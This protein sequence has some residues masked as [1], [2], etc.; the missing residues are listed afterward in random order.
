MNSP[1]PAAGLTDLLLFF[2]GR[3]KLF[4]VEGESMLPSL[5][6]RQRLL[7][8]PLPQKTTAPLNGSV[9]VCRHPADGNLILT[10]RVWRSQGQWL[11]LRGDNP[12]A[13]TDSRH[14]GQVPLDTVIGVV[15]AV[16]PSKAVNSE[17]R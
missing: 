1:L 10:K 13:S 7:V 14:F 2:M 3:R 12:A 4:Q 15:T 17:R 9:V 16:I 8:K 6:P 11:E 5:Q